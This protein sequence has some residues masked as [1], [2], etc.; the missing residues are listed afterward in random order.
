MARYKL[1]YNEL[2][3][4]LQNWAESNETTFTA[5]IANIINLACLKVARDLKLEKF[6]KRVTGTFTD[7]VATLTLSTEDADVIAVDSMIV[8]D[9]TS[10]WP[11]EERS[12]SAIDL[13]NGTGL[14]LYYTEQDVDT[15]RVAPVP[16]DNY[17]YTMMGYQR[18]AELDDTTT[19]SNW[20]TDNVPDLVFLACLEWSNLFL[21]DENVAAEY[22]KR[23]DAELVIA[24]DEFSTQRRNTV[25]IQ[26]EPD[27][28][29][30]QRVER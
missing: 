10:N 6:R 8:N 17:A 20:I 22:R 12:G 19:T 13:Y 28:T 5:E 7:T 25:R 14:P 9:G 16:D 2:D 15:I 4:M 3:T 30:G 27:V 21:M 11:L 23:Y 26:P 29:T 1:D 24:R 18:P